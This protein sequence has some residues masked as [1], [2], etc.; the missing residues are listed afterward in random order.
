MPHIEDGPVCWC[1]PVFLDV[2]PVC[3]GNDVVCARC[4]GARVVKG[5]YGEDK[6]PIHFEIEEEDDDGD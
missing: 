6:L 3:R 5:S 4:G 2:C 1:N